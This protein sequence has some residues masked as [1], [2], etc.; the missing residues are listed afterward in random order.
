MMLPEMTPYRIELGFAFVLFLLFVIRECIV[1]AMKKP[2]ME[3]GNSQTMGARS[4]QNDYFAGGTMELAGMDRAA[5]NLGFRCTVIDDACATR[6]FDYKG[7]TVEAHDAHAA[8]MAAL[9][10]VYATV[11]S[12]RDFIP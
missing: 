8:F 9:A 12:V 7:T 1:R 11:V 2:E 6:H 3:F 5:F 4:I 10:G